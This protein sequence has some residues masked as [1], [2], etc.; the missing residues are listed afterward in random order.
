MSPASGQ[1]E[2]IYLRRGNPSVI[3][4]VGCTLRRAV[5][6]VCFSHA[7]GQSEDIYRRLRQSTAVFSQA[8]SCVS[9][10]LTVVT[11]GTCVAVS[12]NLD[13]YHQ[14]G[15]TLQIS[16]QMGLSLL[17][18]ITQLDLAALLFTVL[19]DHPVNIQRIS[20]WPPHIKVRTFIW[21]HFEKGSH[22]Q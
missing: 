9:S 21:D 1:R 6:A 14:P 11:A 8:A 15:D 10:A 13:R 18:V 5:C 16:T 7:S 22:F 3:L 20:R 17:M 12:Q 19:P 4:P 2:D